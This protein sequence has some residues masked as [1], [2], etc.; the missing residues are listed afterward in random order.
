MAEDWRIRA[1]Y[2]NRPAEAKNHGELALETWHRGD[3]SKE[4]E[5]MVFHD[6][7]DIAYFDL[8]DC[9]AHTTTRLYRDGRGGW[10][11]SRS[12]AWAGGGKR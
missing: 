2:A 6:R 11:P 8:V 10:S 5:L 1:Y 12:A 3:V 7:T 4:I 9:N